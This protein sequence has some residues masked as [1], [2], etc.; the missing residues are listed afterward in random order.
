MN[1][2]RL[3]SGWTCFI[4]HEGWELS[5]H[6]HSI[7]RILGIGAYGGTGASISLARTCTP[8]REV[9]EAEKLLV[10]KSTYYPWLNPNAQTNQ[11]MVQQL[12]NIDRNMV[13]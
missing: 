11:N 1:R 2:A 10:V 7:D 6:Y 4:K 13:T 8:R 12:Q 3:A 9:T 5:Q